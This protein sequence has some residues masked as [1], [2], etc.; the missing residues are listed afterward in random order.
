MAVLC[1]WF[2][3]SCASGSKIFIT[4]ILFL[5]KELKFLIKFATLSEMEGISRPKCYEEMKN[6]RAIIDCT[7]LYIDKPSRPSSQRNTYSQYK[8]RNTFKVLVSQSPLCHF[9]FVSNVY[10][11]SISDKEIVQKSG[12]LDYLEEG[13]IVM[14]DKGFNIQDLLAIQGV[15]LIAP[16][17]M[18]KDNVSA[19]AST[20]TRRI[21]T[22]R[23]HIERMIRKLKSFAILRKC[24]PLTFKGYISSIVK[25]VSSLV[26]LQ[27][28][29]IKT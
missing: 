5:E 19:C 29:I 25:V 24:L 20:L 27:P 18:R 28:R 2:G 23:V 14:A 8:S 7:E 15:R 3:I 26:N 4:W 21:A 12:F 10:S 22:K 9:N 17:I 13:D 6:L 11:G 16:P 1:D